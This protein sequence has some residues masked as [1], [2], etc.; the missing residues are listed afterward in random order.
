MA[1]RDDLN[2][3]CCAPDGDCRAAQHAI[4]IQSS[5]FIRH[6]ALDWT[7]GPSLQV[8]MREGESGSL[9][10]VIQLT[11]QVQNQAALSP[12]E[13]RPVTLPYSWASPGRE[14]G[15]LAKCV[16]K[17]RGRRHANACL[18]LSFPADSAIALHL[19][20][21]ANSLF[22]FTL[23]PLT[24]TVTEVNTSIRVMT[25]NGGLNGRTVE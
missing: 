19:I 15:C 13:R 22:H 6:S 25:N 3:C 4:N 1:R 8:L 16:L 9:L 20:A 11:P 10:S 14:A 12:S 17:R 18:Y 2:A 21:S 5:E 7:L 23:S 24:V